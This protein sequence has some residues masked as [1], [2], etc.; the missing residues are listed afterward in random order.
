MGAELSK[1]ETLYQAASV[2]VVSEHSMLSRQEGNKGEKPFYSTMPCCLY[3]THRLF[4]WNDTLYFDK[5][6][7]QSPQL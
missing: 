4:N 1:T 2:I 6:I 7:E 5:D 3:T